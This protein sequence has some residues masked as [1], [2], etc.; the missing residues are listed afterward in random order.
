M[1]ESQA[2]NKKY[3]TTPV[4]SFILADDVDL[5]AHAK[6]FVLNDGLDDI[7][8]SVRLDSVHFHIEN[9]DYFGT[10]STLIDIFLQEKM[11]VE[12]KQNQTLKR[13]RDELLYLQK[14][15]RI[16]KNKG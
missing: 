9:N 3:T 15:Y 4:L 5:S 11:H 7:N 12:N 2:I 1:A 10:L 16:V 13:F 6:T 14:Y 8:G